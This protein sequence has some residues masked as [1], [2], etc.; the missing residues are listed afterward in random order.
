MDSND[1]LRKGPFLWGVFLITFSLLIFQILQTRILSV[2]AWYY[3][4]F[5]AISVA[6]LGMTVGAVWVYLWRERL[7]S[8]PLPETLSSFAL[9]AAVAMPA[10]VIFQF[11]MVNS[12]ALSATTLVAWTL[13]L[14]VMAV[15]YI[16]SGV[17]VSLALTRS[18]FPTG[19]VYGVDL[20]GAALG[21]VA[22]IGLLNLVDAPTAVMVAGAISGL[23]A[24]AFAASAQ[25]VERERLQ[26]K[27]WWKRPGPVTVGLL[28]LVLF[29][30][31][32]P[33]RFRPLL[34]KDDAEVSLTKVFEKW[35]SYSR[36]RAEQP[37]VANPPLWGPSPNVPLGLQVPAVRMSIDGAAG[38]TMFHYDGTR[39]S[40]SNTTWLAWLTGC[41][42]SIRRR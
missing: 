26:A 21:C 34:V 18:P 41:P 36:I 5:F 10:S 23:S 3:L 20:T 39:Q 17:V 14:G 30:A 22:V 28:L 29:N 7:Q 16:F 27:T 42:A 12:V 19:Q 31:L 8:A 2:V 24:V 9:M 40:I 32:S 1:G 37:L 15:P 38:T 33:A 35:N 25:G 11:C 4:A 6:M 13:L